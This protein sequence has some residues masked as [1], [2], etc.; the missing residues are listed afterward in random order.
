MATTKKAYK[1]ELEDLSKTQLVAR[2]RELKIKPCNKNV[3]YDDLVDGLIAAEPWKKASKKKAAAPKEKKASK[4][5]AAAPKEK[6]SISIPSNGGRK[7]KGRMVCPDDTICDPSS[8]RGRCIK[9]SKKTREPLGLAGLEKLY[10]NYFF[11][12]ENSILGEKEDVLK[13]LEEWGVTTSSTKKK[14]KAVITPPKEKK[15]PAS[16]GRKKVSKCYDPD[17]DEKYQCGKGENSK[18]PYCSAATGSCIGTKFNK[19]YVTYKYNDRTFVGSKAN[20]DKLKALFGDKG[21]EPSSVEDEDLLR[22]TWKDLLREAKK[23]WQE[24]CNKIDNQDECDELEA[25][26]TRLRKLLGKKK[27][28]SLTVPMAPG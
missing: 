5:K 4:K 27:P 22:G 9:R 25:E 6:K 15:K 8:K 14:K 12:D 7:C 21:E 13:Q 18:K 24:A 16:K 26:V 11:D 10:N 23:D 20:I 1:K 17:P 2:C 28:K 3:K 19:T